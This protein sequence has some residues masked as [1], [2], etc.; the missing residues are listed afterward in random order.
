MG[1]RV[2]E[3]VSVVGFDGLEMGRYFIPALTTIEQ[4][5]EDI[6]RSTIEVL[7][8]MMERGAPPRQVTV[9]AALME[10]E[11]VRTL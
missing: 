6:A 8:D 4:P 2:P 11:S 10:R 1:K 7:A 9:E 5:V 3:D